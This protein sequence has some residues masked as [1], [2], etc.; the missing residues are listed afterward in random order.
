MP[1]R[2]HDPTLPPG[3]EQLF[4]EASNS[5]YYW[6]RNTN[7]T[8]YDRPAGGPPARAAPVS[9]GHNGYGGGHHDSQAAAA[10]IAHAY[11]T[12]AQDFPL[13]ADEY[14]RKH[15]V[16]ILERDCPPPLQTF[17]SV[18]FPRD[19]MDEIRQAGYTEPTPIQAQSWPVAIQGR[20]IV[21]IAKTGS[22][23]T[24]GFLLP[25]F[26]HVKAT[27]KSPHYGPT[28]LV[29]APTRELAVQIKEQADKFGRSS[30]I[31]NTCVYGGAPKGP[32]L[33]DLQHGV[34]LVIATPGRL[35]DFL[36]S[37]QVR[38]GQV[39]YLVLDEAD[40]MLDMGFEPQIQRIVHTLPLQRQTLFF[41]ATWPREVKA[42]ASQFV[43]NQ[44]VHVFIG[45]VEEKAVANKSITQHVE[46]VQGYDKM[47]RLQ[48]ILR[49]KPPGSKVIIFCS[50][51]RMCDQLASNLRSFGATAIHGDKKQQ[52][53]DWV[54]ASFREGRMPIMVA[55]DVAARGLD[56]ADVAAVINFDFPNG[57]DDYVHRIGRTGRA[58]AL[59][60]AYTFFSAADSKHA[61][62]LARVMREAGQI[63]PPELEAMQSFGGGGGYGNQRYRSGGGGGGGRFG[64][65]GGGGY[66]A[67]AG[68]YGGGA[69][70]YGGGGGGG[71]GRAPAPA[72]A[73]VAPPGFGASASAYGVDTGRDRHKDR[74]SGK[75][76]RSR[77]PAYRR[78]R[79]RSRDRYTSRHSSRHSPDYNRYSPR[80]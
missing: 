73:P 47:G 65:G 1:E 58:G 39:S 31:R 70:A 37:G 32:Q 49:S 24:C 18:G 14:R 72:P 68:G 33:R 77:S 61:K 53:R 22:G 34:E 35:N 26:L 2:V 62:D 78:S 57:I 28:I 60:E 54:L 51:K 64:G 80:R 11:P 63:V 56:V 79:S 15:D 76:S 6:D 45:A 29:L 48:S 17:E 20:D 55:T 50:T 8:T 9:N 27:H 21:S 7:T 16:N 19:M 44:T 36:E 42:I 66:G 75:R 52:E 46:M 71:F 23:K 59:G 43:R 12:G 4:D 74:Y 10:P 69:G 38:L 13:S 5:R 25:G 3:W 30:G 67:A 40:R 41:S